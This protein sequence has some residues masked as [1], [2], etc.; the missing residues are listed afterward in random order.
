MNTINALWVV[1]HLMHADQPI[2]PDWW[3]R[4]DAACLEPFCDRAGVLGARRGAA[5]VG[6]ATAIGLYDVAAQEA[7]GPEEWSLPAS[8]EGGGVTTAVVVYRPLLSTDPAYGL[9]DTEVL[10][11][12]FFRAEPR[13]HDEFNAWYDT[14]HVPNIVAVEGYENCRRFVDADDDCS[15]LALYDVTTLSVAEGDTA[16][17]ATQ[18]PWSDRVRSEIATYRERRVFVWDRVLR[19]G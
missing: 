19:S 11:G 10:H 13:H 14:E 12:A 4:Y 2:S 17:A 9:P 15:F 3:D 18:S 8:L 7:I 6:S 16:A 1:A 5:V